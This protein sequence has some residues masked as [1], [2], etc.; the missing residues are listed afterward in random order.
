MKPAR[1]LALIFAAMLGAAGSLHAQAPD[2]AQQPPSVLQASVAPPA[3]LP[4]VAKGMTGGK[5]GP[6]AR[7]AR[8]REIARAHAARQRQQSGAS[9]TPRP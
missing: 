8:V 9:T 5:Q 3:F 2:R 4:R 7:K 1:L 6:R